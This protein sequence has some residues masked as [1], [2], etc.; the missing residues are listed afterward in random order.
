MAERRKVS[1]GKTN[2]YCGKYDPTV[3]ASTT[4]EFA[5]AAFRLFHVNTPEHVSYYDESKPLIA[6]FLLYFVIIN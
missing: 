4:N 1:R 3:D 5:V 2:G 6:S